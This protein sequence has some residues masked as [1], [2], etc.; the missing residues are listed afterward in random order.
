MSK[1]QNAPG[2]AEALALAGNL[3]LVLGRLK[4]RLRE[5]TQLG[6][7]SWTQM[8]V[9]ASL[10]REGPTTVS[11]LARAEGMRP[12]S[13]GELV[14]ALKSAR[15]VVGEPDPADGRQTVL[16]LTDAGREHVKRARAAR[17]D[18]L[19]HAINGRLTAEEQRQLAKSLEL[20]QRLV[21]A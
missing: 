2:L 12:Q 20:I 19:A 11:S 10:D 16:S 17:E 7:L 5:E 3:R 21:D 6:E 14:A 8:R 1:P 13:M 9:L 15:F 4:R 18:W